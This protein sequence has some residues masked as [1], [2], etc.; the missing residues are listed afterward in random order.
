MTI[1]FPPESVVGGGIFYIATLDARE[2]SLM[3]SLNLPVCRI[4]ARGGLGLS[5][6][7]K[8]VNYFYRSWQWFRNQIIQDVPEDYAVCEFDCRKPHCTTGDAEKCVIR[9]RSKAQSR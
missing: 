4:E 6:A 2:E 3:Q 1:R 5:S 8:G 7:E 9:L